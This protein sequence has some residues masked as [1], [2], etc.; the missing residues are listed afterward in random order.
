MKYQLELLSPER[1]KQLWII[2]GLSTDADTLSFKEG[3]GVE[4]DL[5][6]GIDQRENVILWLVGHSHSCDCATSEIQALYGV[7]YDEL[8][9]N[10]HLKDGDVL[11][12]PASNVRVH[13]SY[14][15]NAP[16]FYVPALTF[17]VQGIHVVPIDYTVEIFKEVQR[18][19]KIKARVAESLDGLFGD[20]NVPYDFIRHTI[21]TA[22][23]AIE[24]CAGY[25]KPGDK[26]E[27]VFTLVPA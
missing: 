19:H 10:D 7:L 1:D 14:E 17:Q 20:G 6:H 5:H 22:E 25:P 15:E 21:S 16:T 8:Q 12:V 11:C 26:I 27:P 18:I 13:H 23:Q 9:T 24:A 4:P 3:E 2:R